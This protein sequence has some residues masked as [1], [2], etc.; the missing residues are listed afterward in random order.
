MKNEKNGIIL[1]EK[2]QGMWYISKEIIK[3]SEKSA[4]LSDIAKNIAVKGRYTEAI[5]IA[6][7]INDSKV[8]VSTFTSIAF[9]HTSKYSL[10]E[11]LKTLEMLPN[12][13]AKDAWLAG[14]VT[15][16]KFNEAKPA[17]LLPLLSASQDLPKVIEDIL[18][19]MA[20]Y[21]CFF[22]EQPD[23]KILTEMSK[24]LDIQHFLACLPTD[25]SYLSMNIEEWINKIADE[26]DR[27]Q[28]R[29]WAKKVQKVQ[30]GNM[31]EDDFEE[32]VRVIFPN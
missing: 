4:A 6:Q 24:V 14:M 2:I 9:A 31:R 22:N 11:S 5:S 15:S 21:L 23:R 28:V 30:K 19:K 17:D 3:E 13:E 20:I 29:L 26:D 16:L 8:R 25:G 7:Q 12:Q 32:K 18:M 27:D 10:H 1:P